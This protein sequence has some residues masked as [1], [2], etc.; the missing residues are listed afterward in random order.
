MSCEKYLTD[1][2]IVD[3]IIYQPLYCA[4]YI[5]ISQSWILMPIILLSFNDVQIEFPM[6]FNKTYKIMYFN[7]QKKIDV[8][9]LINQYKSKLLQL[10]QHYNID[11]NN[12][13]SLNMI[14]NVEFD[15]EEFLHLRGDSQ[16]ILFEDKFF[17]INITHSATGKP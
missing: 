4:V 12:R 2:N 14:N 7:E 3:N 5:S 13:K 11:L 16:N 15:D 10:Y 1:N 8:M 6:E 9:Y 17:E